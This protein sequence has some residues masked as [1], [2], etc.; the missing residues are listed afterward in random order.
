MTRQEYEDRLTR[1]R[2]YGDRS[3]P[4]WIVALEAEWQ[5]NA[6][7][8]PPESPSHGVAMMVVDA[9]TGRDLGDSHGLFD[10]SSLEQAEGLDPEAFA[11]YPLEVSLSYAKDIA[12][13][14][15]SAPGYL[16]EGFSLEWVTLD[17]AHPLQ[18]TLRFS[19]SRY[20]WFNPSVILYYSDGRRQSLQVAESRPGQPLRNLPDAE[21]ATI[22]G[23]EAWRGETAGGATWLGWT[24]TYPKSEGRVAEV[25]Y[26]LHSPDGLVSLAVLQQVA[27]SLSEG[28]VPRATPTPVRRPTEVATPT[29]RPAQRPQGLSLTCSPK[30]EEAPCAAGVEV[31]RPY[32]YTLYTHCG[33]RWAYFNGRWWEASAAPS[34]AGGDPPR[35]WGAFFDTGTIVL[36]SE[37]L[38]RFTSRTG[39]TA[40]FKLLPI[41]VQEYPGSGCD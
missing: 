34:G 30:K 12:G 18:E 37:G 9:R 36:V 38:A 41:E 32:L 22:H 1:G 29:A 17:L 15:V 19:W 16:P 40:E 24:A 10:L 5:R 39:L 21:P 31:G 35:A 14:P 13:F 20:A 33:V 3:L 7:G 27:E 11:R 25:T 2:S 26:V 28:E 4:V 23:R 8:V 6:L